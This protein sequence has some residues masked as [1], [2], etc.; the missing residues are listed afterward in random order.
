MAPIRVFITGV[1]GYIGSTT[2]D[3]LLKKET[4]I[5]KYS[6]RALVRSPEKAERDI[7]PLSIVPVIG[8]LDDL[9]L[10][11]QEA[12]NT[13]V[14]LHFADADH[15]PA[16]KAILKG[17]LHRP[18]PDGGRKR[19]I[20]I[21]TTGTGVLL[22]DAE[23]GFASKAV[24]YDNDVA[25]LNTLAPTQYHRDVDLEIISPELVGK[26][27]TYIVAPPTIWGT[28]TGTGNHNSIQIPH[29]VEYSLKHGQDLQIG[30]GLNIWS[31][32]H[33][34]DLAHFYITL[35]ELAL[36]ERDVGDRSSSAN[37]KPLP[38]NEDAYY[39]VDDGEFTYGEVAQE[40][41]KVFKE[42]RINDSGEVRSTSPEELTVYWAKGSDVTLGGNS[43]S[44]A[45]KAREILGWKPT[46]TRFK[47]YIAD[48]VHRQI[49]NKT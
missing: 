46:H 31:K 30:K 12:A 43:R 14:F 39:F 23:G 18:R 20:L 45:V 6:F 36:Q 21:H 1:T 17:L 10:L 35:L 26:I 49:K 33:I 24:Y 32:V 4:N 37:S 25:Q 9:D 16:I 28:G 7:R 29:H 15:H 40:I 2:L 19:P 48:E 11:T 22:D 27:D 41:A 3:L 34:V 8:S 38:K 44:R 47:E 13:D 42:L 5:S